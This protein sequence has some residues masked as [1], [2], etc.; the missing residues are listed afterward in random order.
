MNIGVLKS[1]NLKSELNLEYLNTPNL[2]MHNTYVTVKQVFFPHF[3][4]KIVRMFTKVVLIV[5]RCD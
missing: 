4:F 2:F 1:A 3:N 5:S